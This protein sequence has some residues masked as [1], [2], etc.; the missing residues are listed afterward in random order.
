MKGVFVGFP[1]RLLA[2][3]ETLVFDLKP[4][5]IALGP[6]VIWTIVIVAAG[7][8]AGVFIDDPEWLRLAV[9]IG[10]L[11][12]LFLLAVLPFLRW[13]YTNF[14]LTSDRLI[15]RS[16]IIAK[17]SKEIP[18]ERI[19]DVTFS[20]GVFERMVKAGDLM[21]E[22]AGER[23]Q[24]RISNVRNPEQVQLTIYKESE[25]NSNRMFQGGRPDD[26]EPSIPEQIE[27]LARLK[28]QG[29]LSE[30]EFE[31]KKQELLKRL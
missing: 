10:A 29:V 12:A 4:H 22:S 19:N 25:A 30:V 15:T 3:H 20:Q 5:W 18:L 13:S 14:V 7:I 24:T 2:E 26:R 11:V 8:L 31:T 1:R 28:D 16:G 9:W 17:E 21:V 27:A 23:G 6:A